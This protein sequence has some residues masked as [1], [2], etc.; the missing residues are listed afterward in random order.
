MMRTTFWGIML[1]LCGASTAVA[2][3][4][5][6]GF[7]YTRVDR[8]AYRRVVVYDEPVVVVARPPRP[9]VVVEEPCY[10]YSVG[11]RYVS[12]GRVCAAQPW[13]CPRPRCYTIG[14]LK[15]ARPGLFPDR[16]CYTIG[17]LKAAR[18]GLFPDRRCRTPGELWAAQPSRYPRP[19]WR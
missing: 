1:V 3:D 16:R 13:R 4:F 2:D 9:V 18:P 5:A 14:Q 17:Q 11:V 7:R 15:A 19:G 8:P 12:P 10:S 6:I